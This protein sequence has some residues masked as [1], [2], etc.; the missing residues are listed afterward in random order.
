MTDAA[1]LPVTE[2]PREADAHWQ[3]LACLETESGV[4]AAAGERHIA[5]APDGSYALLELAGGTVRQI[6]P[7]VAIDDAIDRAAAVLA[8]CDRARTDPVLVHAL[9]LALAAGAATKALAAAEKR[10]AWE[11][12]RAEGAAP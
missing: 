3:V 11:A 7:R 8:G 5:M 12:Q 2:I 9:A 10:R 4:R 6:G 1:C